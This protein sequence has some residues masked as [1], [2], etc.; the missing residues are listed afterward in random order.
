[1]FIK[2]TLYEKKI[3]RLFNKKTPSYAGPGSKQKKTYNNCQ[4]T[5][6]IELFAV[7]KNQA[8]FFHIAYLQSVPYL[9]LS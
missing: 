5:Y 8:I 2:K 9:T 6:Q 1:M 4:A 3:L 7:W